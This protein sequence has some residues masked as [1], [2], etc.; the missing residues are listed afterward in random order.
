MQIDDGLIVRIT[1]FFHLVYFLNENL[2][3]SFQIMSSLLVV[4]TP[5]IYAQESGSV[6][7]CSCYGPQRHH[8]SVVLY[9]L[10]I[11]IQFGNNFC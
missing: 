6:M 7:N 11:P 5:N 3:D 8:S 4:L 2:L 9:F 10:S 1:E